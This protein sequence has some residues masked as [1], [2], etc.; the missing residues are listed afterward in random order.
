M[1]AERVF[2]IL[3]EGYDGMALVATGANFPD[4]IAAAPLAAGKIW[5]LF[6]A[7]PTS[8]LSAATKAVMADNG[9]EKAVILGG[10]G[11]VSTAVQADLVMLLGSAADVTRLGGLTRYDTAV[12][13]AKYAVDEQGFMWDRVGITTGE[14]YPDALTGGVLQGKVGSVMLLTTPTSL[15]PAAAAALDMHKDEIG[16]VTYFGGTL[17]VSQAVRNAIALILQF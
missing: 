13:I 4:A 14:N 15:H 12:V 7:H 3:G 5:Q 6:L 10:T 9:V 1:I 8:G 17:A 16:T 11:A 2:D